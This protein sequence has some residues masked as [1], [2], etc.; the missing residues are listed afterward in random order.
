MQNIDD[1]INNHPKLREIAVAAKDLG[2]TLMTGK[3]KTKE[4]RLRNLKIRE[5][6][7]VEEA[8]SQVSF[9]MGG[10][11]YTIKIHTSYNPCDMSF[12]K[13]G[14]ISLPITRLDVSS[15]VYMPFFYRKLTPDGSLESLVISKVKKEMAFEIIMLKLRPIDSSGH[16]MFLGES[17]D[18]YYEWSSSKT[19]E[20]ENLWHN[21]NRSEY[22]YVRS[23]ALYQRKAKQY[24]RSVRESLGIKSRSRDKRIIAESS[25]LPVIV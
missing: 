23:H 13:T 19:R 15:P 4:G 12:N 22:D 9:W 7:R 16:L 14:R 24:Y 25:G 10:D 1:V 21:I 5:T 20:T 11:G 6:K 2:F 18:G 8:E 3:D 17:N